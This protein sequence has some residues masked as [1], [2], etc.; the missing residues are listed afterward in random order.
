MARTAGS[1]GSLPEPAGRPPSG[2]PGGVFNPLARQMARQHA[3]PPFRREPRL[4]E[5]EYRKVRTLIGYFSP[6]VRGIEHLP[7]EGPVLVVGNH[8]CVYFMPD[9]WVTGMAIVERR[10][11]DAPSYGL[12]YD[13]LLTVPLVGSFLRRLGAIP[14]G[15][16]EAE[17][18]LAQGALVLVYPGGDW[19]ACRP[20]TARNT[21]DFAG[22]TGFAALALRT[23]VP[24]VPVVAH[25]SHD[26]VVVLS[27]GE[28]IA[29]VLGLGGLKINV[30]PVML[31]PPFGVAT[32]LTPP[33]PLPSSVTV[34]FLPAITWPDLGPEAAADRATV[35][36]CAAQVVG[37]MQDALDRLH[38]ERPHPVLRGAARLVCGVLPH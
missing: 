6:E 34:E 29:R 14:A 38:A 1:P 18:A 7:A 28:A 9:F 36:R 15:N 35:Q 19:E 22:R 10:G 13:L 23:G 25:G 17:Q 3:A 2:G 30:F 21:V 26:A 27:R 33:L 5:R 37:V 31:G 16:D 11:A 12:T 32:F 4:I 8:N 20:W 24:V